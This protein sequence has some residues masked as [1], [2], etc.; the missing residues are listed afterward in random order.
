MAS[1]HEVEFVNRTNFHWVGF[2]ID[3][4]GHGHHWGDDLISGSVDQGESLTVDVHRAHSRLF[5]IKIVERR[6][7]RLYEVVWHDVDLENA[8]KVV[9]HYNRETGLTSYRVIRD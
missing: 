3:Y 9:M 6:H 2:Y 1:A 8:N 4:D 5:K 7:G